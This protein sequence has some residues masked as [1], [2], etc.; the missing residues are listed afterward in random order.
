MSEG[1]GGATVAGGG[2]G[3]RAAHDAVLAVRDEV[4]KV[5]VG[6][7]GVLSG[8]IAALLVNGHVLLEGVPGVAKTLLAKTLAASFDMRFTRLQFTPD[9]MP[10]DVIGQQLVVTGPGGGL[11]FQFR[12]GPVFT[13]LL[14]ADEIN[15]TPPKTQAALL[16]AMEERQVTFDGRTT[17]LPDPFLVIATQNPVEYEGTYPL[18]EA[19]LDRFLFKLHVPYPT[20]EQELAMLGRHDAGMNPHDPRSAG[21]RAVATAADLAAGR[22]AIRRIRVEPAVQEYVVSLSRATR[23]SPSLQLGVSPRGTTWLLHAAKAWAWLSGRAFVTP[24][25]VKAVAKPCLRH[26]IMVRPE[27]ELDGTTADAVLDGLLATVPTPR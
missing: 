27:L 22:A 14:L 19:Q 11:A 12:E 9:L 10:S 8:L 23:E 13:N 7:D 17:P 25:D 3:A 16:E 6:Q 18:P 21:V 20:A 2:D 5:I 26:R 4:G 24:D 1:T 15:R